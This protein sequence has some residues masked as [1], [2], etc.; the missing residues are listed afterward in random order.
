MP[1][2]VRSTRSWPRRVA[3][4]P[5]IRGHRD[6]GGADVELVERVDAGVE[7]EGLAVGECVDGVIGALARGDDE[8]AVGLGAGSA[9]ERER[10]RRNHE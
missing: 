10:N 8:I 5:G 6:V 3:R 1:E 4:S 9:R 2:A 7:A